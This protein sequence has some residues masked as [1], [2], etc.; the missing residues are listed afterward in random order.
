MFDWIPKRLV[1]FVLTSLA[2]V[3]NQR[4]G[5]GM[6]PVE[7]AGLAGG[8]ATYIA[9]QTKHDLDLAKLGL[10]KHASKKAP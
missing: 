6:S 9:T 8:A 1:T 7:I 2:I 3:F 5:L 10:G 4:L